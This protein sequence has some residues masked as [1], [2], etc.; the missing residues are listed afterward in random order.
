MEIGKLKEILEKHE[1][2]LNAKDGG[3]R[4][5][6]EGADLD[7]ANL[8]GVDLRGANLWRA[9]LLETDLR[10]ANLEEAYLKDADLTRAN[11]EG[12]D[13][14]AA[15]LREANL[16]RAN[17]EGADLM[18][19]DLM[20]ANLIETNLIGA[21][22]RGANLRAAS[23][24]VADLRGACLDASNIGEADLW[25]ATISREVVDKLFPLACPESG[26]FIGWK[27]CSKS[28]IV[29]LQVLEDAR[30]SSAF[31]RKCRCDKAVVLAIEDVDGN[32]VQCDCA[33]SIY[34]HDFIYR[35]GETVSVDNFDTDR[36]HECASG[37]HF[38]ITRREAVDYR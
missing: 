16:W 9:S 24:R 34:D 1:K 15:N 4:A 12:A 10:K 37:I 2:W 19:A 26:A 28:L 13:L 38:F 36:T 27:K 7:G 8:E 25:G 22:L 31:G 18:E 32:P 5:N 35:I 14:E 23:L 30:R 3:E 29:K 11:L 6:L 20:R 21:D 17:L 33:V